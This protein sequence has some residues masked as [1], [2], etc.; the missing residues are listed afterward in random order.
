MDGEHSRSR[1]AGQSVSRPATAPV[2]H[3]R[4][5]R[6]VPERYP[7]PRRPD[8][9][10]HRDGTARTGPAPDGATAPSRREHGHPAPDGTR[11]R[12]PVGVPAA[13]LSLGDTHAAQADGE[14]CGTEVE[15]S[16][17]V[18][19]RVAVEKDRSVAFPVLERTR[20]A[21]AADPR[22]SRRAS[23]RTCSSRP[24]RRCDHSS[25]RWSVV[26][27]WRRLRHTCWPAWPP[28]CTSLRSSTCECRRVDAPG[29]RSTGRLTIPAP[30]ARRADRSA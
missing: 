19:I 24:A 10:H 4:W 9:R 6:G 29:P 7:Y 26:P 13:L 5:T 8:D 11:L 3:L 22:S 16:S 30:A 1:P 20:A 18:T 15:I 28:T 2:H 14:V 25:T 21:A 23:A 12:L 27:G 17:T